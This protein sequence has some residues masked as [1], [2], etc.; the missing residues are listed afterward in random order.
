M[1]AE[2]ES[3]RV[4]ETNDRYIAMKTMGRCVVLLAAM[5]LGDAVRAAGATGET[6]RVRLIAGL[7]A[8]K[9]Y[10]P[11]L[12]AVRALDSGTP[13]SD[14]E[15]AALLAFLRRTDGAEG[16]EE[17]ELAA[18]KNDVTEHLLRLPGMPGDLARDLLAMQADAAQSA[19]WRDYCVQFLGRVYAA[20]PDAGLR[21]E[22]RERLYAL[23]DSADTETCGTALLALASLKGNREIDSSRAA[24]RALALARDA[25]AGEGLRLTSLQIAAGLGRDEAV[26]L[27]RAWLAKEKSA[28]LR[29][30]AIGVL[31]GRG[32]PADRALVGPY[33]DNPDPRLK[34]AAREALK[35]LRAGKRKG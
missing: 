29:A 13:L 15:R 30:V 33:L 21:E 3:Y 25:S 4:I 14:G 24:S 20:T 8:E 10:L 11:R 18:V 22:V 2:E 6:A 9:A 23:A 7:D 34:N 32:T 28:N 35:R 26:P 27:A 12:K 1:K 16:T 17:M 19:T 5:T 31:G